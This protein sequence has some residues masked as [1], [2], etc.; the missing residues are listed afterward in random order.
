[1]AKL[2]DSFRLNLFLVNDS[3]IGTKN[4]ESLYVSVF[5]EDNIG[6]KRRQPIN[7]GVT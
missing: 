4:F 6:L 2:N 7:A 3:K 1:M 5:N